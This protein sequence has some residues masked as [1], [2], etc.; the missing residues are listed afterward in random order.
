M[1]DDYAITVLCQS[2]MIHFD[3]YVCRFRAASRSDD[4]HPNQ[5][6]GPDFRGT[7]GE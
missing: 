6:H 4:K 5:E 3:M 7:N 1:I 2:A